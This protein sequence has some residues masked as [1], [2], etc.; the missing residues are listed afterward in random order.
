[1]FPVTRTL[2]PLCAKLTVPRTLLPL[3]GSSFALA[4]S[5]PPPHQLWMVSQPVSKATAAREAR[6]GFVTWRSRGR[7]LYSFLGRGGSLGRRHRDALV[8]LV[9][10]HGLVLGLAE[11]VGVLG[12]CRGGLFGLGSLFRIGLG[13]RRRQLG[14]RCSNHSREQPRDQH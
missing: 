5:P 6:T 11:L 13:R 3:V 10:G 12:L 4:F 8:L 1:M 14:V 7:P 2:L 9:I